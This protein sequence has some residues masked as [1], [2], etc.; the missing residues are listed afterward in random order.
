MRTSWTATGNV[1]PVAGEDVVVEAGWNM[2]YDLEGDSPIFQIVTINGRLSFKQESGFTAAQNLRCKQLFIRAG[3]LLI[4]SEATPFATKA[5]ITLFGEYAERSTAYSSS[6]YAG[7]KLIANLGK[8]H[9]YGTVPSNEIV[10]LLA[11]AA[12]AATTITVDTGLTWVA[13]DNIF[14]AATS[15]KRDASDYATISAYDSVTG[16]ITLT[17]G[18]TH[19]HFGKATTTAADYNNAF[20]IRGEVVLLTRNVRI[21]GDN[22]DLNGDWGG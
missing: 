21:V 20:D 4:G 18:L 9:L 5:T 6:I 10:R 14:L 12:I 13:G 7:N 15:Y 11:P 1:P 8:V 19:Y 16:V 3:E 17:A 2:I 22:T